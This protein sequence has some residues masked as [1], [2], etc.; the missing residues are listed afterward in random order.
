M[1]V[2]GA[3]EKSKSDRLPVASLLGCLF[4]LASCFFLLLA[5]VWSAFSFQALP[6]GLITDQPVSR[7][8]AKINGLCNAGVLSAMAVAGFALASLLMATAKPR[9]VIAPSESRDTNT[10]S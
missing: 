4:T 6:G 3:R 8:A 5:V 2:A 1:A 10:E 7:L 9:A